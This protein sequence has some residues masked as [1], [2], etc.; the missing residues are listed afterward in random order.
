MR[1]VHHS[2]CR[3][4]RLMLAVI[5][6]LRARASSDAEDDPKGNRQISN[7]HTNSPG[8]SSDVKER[9]CVRIRGEE[10][11]TARRHRRSADQASRARLSGFANVVVVEAAHRLRRLRRRPSCFRDEPP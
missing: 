11:G 3:W 6:N 2:G 5:D 7:T 10:A 1:Q 4:W 9:E 8:K